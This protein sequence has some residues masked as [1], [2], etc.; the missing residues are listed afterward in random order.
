[1]GR[2]IAERAVAGAAA[3][4]ITAGLVLVLFRF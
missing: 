3:V 2:Y 4:L 1:M